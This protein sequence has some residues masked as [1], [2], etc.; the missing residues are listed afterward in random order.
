M[1]LA[2]CG[3]EECLDNKNSLPLAGFYASGWGDQQ[4]QVDSISLMG[5]GAPGDSLILDNAR[6][7]SQVFLPFRIDENRTDFRLYYDFAKSQEGR[8][9]YDDISFEYDIDPW[10]VSAACGAIYKYKI[11][12]I[13]HTNLLIDS[14]S[15]PGGVI[16]NVTGV[17][18]NIYFRVNLQEEGAE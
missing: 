4:I 6:N 11:R 7:V 1:L 15:C 10:F 9:P 5:I 16:D 13:S 12:N 17:N 18:I 2:A 3:T 14:I 8:V